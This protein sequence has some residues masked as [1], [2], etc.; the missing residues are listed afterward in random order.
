MTIRIEVSQHLSAEDLA[1]LRE[2]G[3]QIM[4]QL[5]DAIA[6]VNTSMDAAI[7]RVQGDIA[8]LTT[9]V[10]DL[11]AQVASGGATPDDLAML[12]TLQAKLDAL[13]PA[14]P[15]VLPTPAGP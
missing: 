6:K 3:N 8:A 4:S 15:D 11:Q 14:K 10:A 13:D 2:L 7:G 9:R 5:A 12:A 1:T